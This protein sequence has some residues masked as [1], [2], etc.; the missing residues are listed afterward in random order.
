MKQKPMTLADMLALRK[1][2]DP[3]A[4]DMIAMPDETMQ[5]VRTASGSESNP[6]RPD[7]YALLVALRKVRDMSTKIADSVILRLAAEGYDAFRPGGYHD[8][9]H[10]VRAIII[11]EINRASDTDNQT[12]LDSDE[13]VTVCNK[14]LQSSCWQGL[15]MCE[16]A[17]NAGTI[18]MTRGEL[19][20]LG[21]EHPDYFTP[22]QR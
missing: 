10:I 21:R 9:S 11:E 18:E 2:L 17:Q 5:D 7:L 1:E 14:C 3:D 4:P 15:F 8:L 12:P 16:E 22:K 13:R 6:V 20:R 19:L